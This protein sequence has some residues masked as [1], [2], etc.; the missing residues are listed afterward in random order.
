MLYLFIE[1]YKQP[2]ATKLVT[3]KYYLWWFTDIF[4]QSKNFSK[5]KKCPEKHN[6]KILPAQERKSVLDFKCN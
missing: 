4:M 6:A 2:K 3:C 5:K 1:D